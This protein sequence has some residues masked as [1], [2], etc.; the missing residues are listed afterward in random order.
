MRRFAFVMVLF[1]AVLLALALFLDNRQAGTSLPVNRSHGSAQ[2]GG[3]FELV[4]HLGQPFTQENLLG[5][6]SLVYFGFTYC[7]DVCPTTLLTVA[8]TLDLLPEEMRNQIVP[9]FITVDPQRD[10]VAVMAQYVS[11]FHPQ[12][13][14]L[15]GSAAQVAQA[16][17]A[18]KVYYSKVPAED[19]ASNY[20]M[21]H[22]GYLYLMG[23][24]GKYLAHFPHNVTMQSLA[25]GLRSHMLAAK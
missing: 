12:L 13:V 11:N 19:D 15:T 23:P 3:A 18:Y 22:S 6:Y 8:E 20:L 4:D 17:K 10:T 21:D 25:D 2:I 1:S 9:I 14:G 5:H 7:P 16:A 24:E